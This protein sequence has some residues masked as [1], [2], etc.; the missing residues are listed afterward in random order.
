[1]T[2]DG[3]WRITPHDRP[4]SGQKKPSMEIHRAVLAKEATPRRK[5]IWEYQTQIAGHEG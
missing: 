2:M 3:K 4:A 1:M 5:S